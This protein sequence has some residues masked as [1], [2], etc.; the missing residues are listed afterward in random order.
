M[1]SC[2]SQ[3]EPKENISEKLDTKV[4][5]TESKQVHDQK[6]YEGEQFFEERNALQAEGR[7]ASLLAPIICRLPNANFKSLGWF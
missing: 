4:D 5:K 7:A 1:D 2:V 6:R 3:E